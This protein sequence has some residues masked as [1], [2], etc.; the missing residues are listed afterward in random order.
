MFE[1]LVGDVGI[2]LGSKG[3]RVILLTAL[4]DRVQRAAAKRGTFG[5]S[6]PALV[7]TLDRIGYPI[8]T[9]SK[10][11][12]VQL[13]EVASTCAS[14]PCLLDAVYRCIDGIDAWYL[15]DT[16]PQPAAKI[17]EWVRD[18]LATAAPERE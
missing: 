1:K 14:K 17:V 11:Y 6:M 15:E 12:L 13:P 5:P 4:Y 7:D 18:V 10:D 16:V 9:S 8:T 3:I 2:H